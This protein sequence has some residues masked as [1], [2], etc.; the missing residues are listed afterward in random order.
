MKKISL[1]LVLIA[2]AVFA[3]QRQPATRLP[4]PASSAPRSASVPSSARTPSVASTRS[5]TF[6]N[7]ALLEAIR[8]HA[9]GVTVEGGGT[10]VRLLPDD[11]DG[12]PHQRF[13]IRVSSG[14]TVLI[15][16]NIEL[17]AR[18]APLAEGDEVAFRGEYLWNEKG[19]VVH[20]THPDPARRHAAGW[21]HRVR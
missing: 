8:S 13:L 11:R 14:A 4:G 10:V 7:T 17:A 16:H 5:S 9:S 3:I 2:L 19:G 6:D 12:S 20:W 18:L 1:V 15:A 21:I